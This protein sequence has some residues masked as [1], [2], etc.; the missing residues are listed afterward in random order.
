MEQMRDILVRARAIQLARADPADAQTGILCF[1][2]FA[3]HSLHIISHHVLQIVANYLPYQS[4]ADPNLRR[5]QR[6]LHKTV[7]PLAPRCARESLLPRLYVNVKQQK[8]HELDSGWPISIMADGCARK[9]NVRFECILGWLI[10]K[11][12]RLKIFLFAARTVVVGASRPSTIM[13]GMVPMAFGRSTAVNL[14]QLVRHFAKQYGIQMQRIAS[15]A[16]DG[17][18]NMI[19]VSVCS[20]IHTPPCLVASSARCILRMVFRPQ[21]S[22]RRSRRFGAVKVGRRTGCCVHTYKQCVFLANDARIAKSKLVTIWRREIG[23]RYEG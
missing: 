16:S 14:Q 15:A 20:C 19:K 17:A 18:S 22:S 6:S 23:A 12:N 8:V 3:S 1:V 10:F 21:G 7:I 2:R 13:L 5:F 4:L 11:W 9:H